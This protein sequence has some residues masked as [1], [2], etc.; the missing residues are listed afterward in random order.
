ME[1]AIRKEILPQVNLTSIK[2]DKFKTSCIS[3]TFRLQ[4]ERENATKNALLPS[5]LLRGCAR[6]P[7]ME[8]LSAA[9]D[10]LF[11]TRIEPFVRKKGEVQCVGLYADFVDDAFVP[12]G[13]KLLEKVTEL[14]GQ[15][16]LFP[17][18]K[19]GL[20]NSDYVKSERENL[21]DRIK[22]RINDKQLYAA[23]RLNELMCSG[24]AYSVDSLGNADDALK[25]TSQTLTKHY[26]HILENS[27]IEVFYCGSADRKRVE[28]ALLGALEALPRSQSGFSVAST[29]VKTKTGDVRYFKDNLDV[30]QG[31][32]ALGFRL[33]EVM[34]N[35][36]L[37]PIMVF[38]AVYGGAVTS[39]LFT[40]VRE[41]LSLCYYASSRIERHKGLLMVYS[42]IEF[43]KYDD[44]LKEILHQM[45]LCTQGQIGSDELSSAKKSVITDLN[46]LMDD[47]TQ[48]ENYYLGQALD[49][50]SCAPDM[51]ASL[52]SEVCAE[53]VVAVAK[54]V[55]LDSVYF[56]QNAERRA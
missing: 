24:E 49:S 48:L 35:S 43:D 6:Y 11:G 32:L 36:A 5:V 8:T 1:T 30:T 51:L 47:Q 52:V 21:S 31:K 23:T 13:E 3:V 41:K 40:N 17:A 56:L 7:D 10:E 28:T 18:T 19:A 9:M 4:L 42:G 16:L 46:S 12:K 27:S 14:M 29:D 26:R 50:T 38:N 2:T 20:L 33:G 39:K 53:E 34:Q 15:I 55:R 44:A 54:S 45:E 25:I 22:A 37:A